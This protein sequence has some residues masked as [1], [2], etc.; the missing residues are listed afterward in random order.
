M[1]VHCLAFASKDNSPAS[2]LLSGA[3]DGSIGIW[4]LSLKKHMLDLLGHSS[5]VT[6]IGIRK[7]G[8][9]AL[10][11]GRYYSETAC[12]ILFG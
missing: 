7:C 1:D 4:D 8:K 2:H 11:C 9:L 3:A 6:G 10:S 5:C 12:G